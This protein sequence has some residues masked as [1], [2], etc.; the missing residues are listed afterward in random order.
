[1]KRLLFLGLRCLGM[2]FSMGAAL[3]ASEMVLASSEVQPLVDW[4]SGLEALREDQL[5]LL[6]EYPERLHIVGHGDAGAL[7]LGGRI[8]EA[9]ELALWLRGAGFKGLR[10]VVIWS[11]YFGL[12]REGLEEIERASGARV[13]ATEVELRGGESAFS[14][15]ELQTAGGERY[16]GRMPFE[17]E[18]LRQYE[19]ALAL[20]SLPFDDGFV[21]LNSGNNSSTNVIRLN[22]GNSLG[23]TNIQFSQDSSATDAL[24]S[25]IFEAQ[26][27]DIIGNVL[28]TDSAGT[29]YVI[30][31][32]V[33]WRSPS[34]NDPHTIVFQPGP[35]LYTLSTT[36][37]SY[38]I[39]G[40]KYIGLTRNDSDPDIDGANTVSGNAADQGLLDALND[41]LGSIPKLSIGTVTVGEGDGAV[42][43]AV[44]LSVASTVSVSVYAST[45][46]GT[47]TAGQD[48][49]ALVNQLVTF[50]AGQTSQTVT[51]SIT[52]DTDVEPGETF[53]VI[54]SD[55][56][57]ASI[58]DNEGT[59]TI[60]DDDSA[61]TTPPPAPVI[62]NVT[63]TGNDPAP[64]DL[65]SDDNT[66]VLTV[67]G[68]SGATLKVYTSGGSLIPTANYTVTE[69]GGTYT[70]D[71]GPNV[72]ADG[73]YYVTLTDAAG[74][75]SPSSNSFQIYTATSV[76]PVITNV[77]ESPADN[78]ASDLYSDDNTQV[79]TVTGNPGETLKVFNLDGTLI[80]VS[81]YTVSETAGTYTVDF[82]TNVLADGEYYITLTGA[83]ASFNDDN[84][85]HI[86]GV[87]F[88]VSG[89]SSPLFGTPIQNL[90]LSG[91][92][93]NSLASV[94]GRVY[95]A[96]T[97][98][99]FTITFG[100]GVTGLE[101]YL[102]YFRGGQLGGNGYSSYDFAED[103]VFASSFNGVTASGTVLDTS[104]VTF[105]SGILRFSD[106]LT[107]LTVS[108]TGTA[109]GGDQGFTMAAVA[110]SSNTFT[111]DTSGPAAPVVVITEDANNDAIISGVEL[112]GAIDVTVTLPADAAVGD[113]LT[114]TNGSVPQTFT[115]TSGQITAGSVAT[116]FASP[117]DGNAITV[118]AYVTDA[119]GNQGANGSDSATLDLSGPAAPVVVITEDANND[120]II[121]GVEL[122]G[123][124]DV[125]VTLPADAA[126]GD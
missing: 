84:S 52:N 79:L 90:N 88:S 92:E 16:A 107:S 87:P 72:L 118:T 113:V 110:S 20:V 74:N 78:D 35:T 96:N 121:S 77:T 50:S 83:F 49:S 24:G 26:G 108:A 3:D 15:W 44:T 86:G 37:G 34:G 29:E 59:I 65:L 40:T 51:V 122:S 33:K 45:Q 18:R 6:S 12:D 63:E 27:N 123:A 66:Q 48:Y 70:V 102:Y 99:S 68:E 100:G 2:I 46:D 31:G 61:D 5:G 28:I 115:L 98:S 73:E 119:V 22:A 1:M 19:G 71:F 124:I 85:G 69:I 57:G 41:A 91:S 103:F 42:T 7:W 11:C 38:A 76:T 101:L 17:T 111:I 112:S 58:I 43:V 55:S 126:V 60:I 47:A 89:L 81:N 39:D 21:G 8:V 32:F 14:A 36:T 9:E 64:N 82:G 109:T 30:G 104:S 106:A 4:E 120:A 13:Y 114:V 25:P 94:V 97:A 67:T 116:T 125:T 75:E 93:W 23:W 117:G 62:T 105:A 54:L 95:D 56:V 10:E 53:M 80:P